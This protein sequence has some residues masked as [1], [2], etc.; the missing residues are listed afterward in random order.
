MA[1]REHKEETFPDIPLKAS[2]SP[3]FPPTYPLTVR[4]PEKTGENTPVLKKG[5]DSCL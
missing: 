2:V 4:H 1:H 5:P 3:V